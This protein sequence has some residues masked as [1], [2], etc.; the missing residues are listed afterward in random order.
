MN[1]VFHSFIHPYLAGIA[2]LTVGIR[3]LVIDNISGRSSSGSQHVFSS[4]QA[5]Y[6][7]LLGVIG[8]DYSGYQEE[9]SSIHP[10]GDKI[11]EKFSTSLFPPSAESRSGRVVCYSRLG[12]CLTRSVLMSLK[13]LNNE[14]LVLGGLL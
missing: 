7:T 8:Q 3:Q 1:P 9:E 2:A 6:Q 14:G 10:H 11:S 4:D 12:V 5:I 13:D